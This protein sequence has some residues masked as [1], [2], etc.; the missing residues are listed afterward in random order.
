MSVQVTEQ[1]TCSSIMGI[2]G[3]ERNEVR[4]GITLRLITDTIPNSVW[5]L[6]QTQYEYLFGTYNRRNRKIY[7]GLITDAIGRSIWDLLQ[8]QYEDLFGTYYRRNTKIYLGLITDAIRR[9]VWDL[10]QTQ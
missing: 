2:Y 1:S 3:T 5:D 10:L 7:L 9:S 6:L 8:T 4:N